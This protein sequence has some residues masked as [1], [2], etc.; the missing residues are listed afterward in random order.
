MREPAAGA[1]SLLKAGRDS[2]AN[3]QQCVAGTNAKIQAPRRGAGLNVYLWCARLYE[4]PTKAS[5]ATAVLVPA[6]GLT[7]LDVTIGAVQVSVPPEDA[8]KAC[9][10]TT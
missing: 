10:S 8:L 6:A 5:G 1:I 4:Q 3:C 9:P 7:G 2:T